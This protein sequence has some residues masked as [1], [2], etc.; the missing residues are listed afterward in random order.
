MRAYNAKTLFFTGEDKQFF[1]KFCYRLFD[2]DMQ[3]SVHAWVNWKTWVA[4]E[5]QLIQDMW[6]LGYGLAPFE[7]YFSS[8][9]DSKLSSLIPQ[10]VV[11]SAKHHFFYLA[12]KSPIM[13]DKTW[14][15]CDN[16]FRVKYKSLLKFSKASQD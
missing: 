7:T 8:C 5:D 14:V 11:P 1:N 12:W 9:W 10:V 15:L 6:L 3:R 13:I 2:N 16:A 4:S